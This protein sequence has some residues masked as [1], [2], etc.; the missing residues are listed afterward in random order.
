MAQPAGTQHFPVYSQLAVLHR[1]HTGLRVLAGP[2]VMGARLAQEHLG[3]HLPTLY[4]SPGLLRTCEAP[5]TLVHTY[6]SRVTPRW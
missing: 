6:W 2:Q 5:V 3:G 4:T 1:H